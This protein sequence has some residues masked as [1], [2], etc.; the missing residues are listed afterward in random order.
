MWKRFTQMAALLAQELER[1]SDMLTSFQMVDQFNQAASQTL[2]LT[3]VLL[4]YLVQKLD[5]I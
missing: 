5:R 3:C 4:I 1:Q 2:A